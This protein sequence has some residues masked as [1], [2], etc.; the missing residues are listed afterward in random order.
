MA[1]ERSA[2]AERAAMDGYFSSAGAAGAGM[3][4]RERRALRREWDAKW[5]AP[6]RQGN[7]WWIDRR[8]APADGP[9]SNW[10]SVM[11][12]SVLGWI[13]ESRAPTRPAPALTPSQCPSARRRSTAPGSRRTRATRA[14]ACSGHARGGRPSCATAEAPAP[15]ALSDTHEDVY[16]PEVTVHI[17]AIGEAC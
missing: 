7:L 10:R 1:V 4:L 17:N 8:A 12:E 14:W 11:G 15:A 3:H 2:G 5:G 16:A 6:K 13:R 9:T